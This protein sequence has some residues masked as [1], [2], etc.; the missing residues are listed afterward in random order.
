MAGTSLDPVRESVRTRFA[1]SGLTLDELG[2][3]MG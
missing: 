2:T 3:R 1:K